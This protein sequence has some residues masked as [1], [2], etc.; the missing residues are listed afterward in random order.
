MHKQKADKEA[1]IK[2][3]HGDYGPGYSS[4]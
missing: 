4:Y 2:K 1:K 3:E